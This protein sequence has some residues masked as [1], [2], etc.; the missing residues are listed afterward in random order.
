M[1]DSEIIDLFFDRNERALSEVELKY[2]AYLRSIARR[3][4]G[5]ERDAEESVSDAF[6][7]SWNSIPPE[8][9]TD[10]CAYIGRLCRNASIDRARRLV[11]QKRGGGR[12]EFALSE[13]GEISSEGGDVPDREAERRVFSRALDRF[14]EG[15]P[16]KKRTIFVQRYWY[17][18]SVSEIAREQS[19][20]EAAV[21]M[22]LNRLREQLKQKL[23][24]EGL[25]YE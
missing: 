2:G 10:L 11:S 7:K 21:K 9:P 23:V 16:R 18:L 19:M 5:D 17:L 6:L 8:R 4:L 20:S 15:L 25:Y 13:L 22:Q 1:K 12:V 24:K 14:L 3:I